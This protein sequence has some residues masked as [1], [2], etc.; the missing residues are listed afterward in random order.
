[1]FKEFGTKQPKV[2]LSKCN[3]MDFIDERYLFL[4][5]HFSKFFIPQSVAVKANKKG[6]S[7]ESNSVMS[8]SECCNFFL[9]AK[10]YFHL[11]LC[12]FLSYFL[13]PLCTQTRGARYH[14]FLSG[15]C[16]LYTSGYTCFPCLPCIHYFLLKSI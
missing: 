11:L 6:L 13:W 10:V 15:F 14:L 5:K 16:P 4:F 12:H 2:L 7:Y 3:E 1:M 8:N 9:S